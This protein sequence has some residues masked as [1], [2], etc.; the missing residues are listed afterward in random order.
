MR[1]PTLSAFAKAQLWGMAV[2][3]ALAL[4]FAN[5]MQLGL[6]IFV[7]GFLAAWIAWEFTIGV[8]VAAE[9]KSDA[10]TL[11]RAIA[12]GFFLPWVG[13]LIAYALHALRP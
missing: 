3:F 9:P 12:T 7:L 13:F 6:A 4:H 11:A 8:R 5:Q 2:G 1:L 10:P